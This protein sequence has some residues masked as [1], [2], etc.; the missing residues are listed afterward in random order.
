MDFT[1][2]FLAS[3]MALM[4]CPV[5]FSGLL[6]FHHYHP[7]KRHLTLLIVWRYRWQVLVLVLTR[8]MPNPFSYPSPVRP[9]FLP[10][11]SW[12][13]YQHAQTQHEKLQRPFSHRAL[14]V[15][16]RSQRIV[17]RQDVLC[18]PRRHHI[19]CGPTPAFCDRDH[20]FWSGA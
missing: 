15:S 4:A 13:K 8:F 20:L 14:V 6:K 11:S 9:S 12:S 18:V 16:R 1:I 10:P 19:V 7:M 17:P 2:R 3:R 5:C